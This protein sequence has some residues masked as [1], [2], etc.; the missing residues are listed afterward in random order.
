MSYLKRKDLEGVFRD[1]KIFHIFY[2]KNQGISKTKHKF[3]QKENN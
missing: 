3:N 1:L 2:E